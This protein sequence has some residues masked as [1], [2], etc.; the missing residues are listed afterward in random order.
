MSENADSLTLKR[1]V[2]KSIVDDIGDRSDHAGT[3]LRPESV[4][5]W[6]IYNYELLTKQRTSYGALV[7]MIKFGAE[8]K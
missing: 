7:V 1:K 4:V 2:T 6:Q 3:I 8:A 5:S